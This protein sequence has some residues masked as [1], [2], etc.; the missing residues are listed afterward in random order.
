MADLGPLAGLVD[1]QFLHISGNP[2]ASLAPL[3]GLPLTELYASSLEGADLSGLGQIVS[4]QALDLG[5]NA[6][7]DIGELA[8]LVHL[9]SLSLYGNQLA[10]LSPLAGL[11]ALQGLNLSAN[12]LTDLSPLAGLTAMQRLDLDENAIVDLAPLTEMVALTRLTAEENAIADLAALAGMTALTELDLSHNQ[13][14]DL[15]P[16]AGLHALID[17]DLAV[18]HVVDVAP[19]ALPALF[20]LDLRDN[21][22]VD[23]AP[24]LGA[25]VLERLDVSG[26]PFAPSMT[27]LAAHPA[28]QSVVAEAAGLTAAPEF[29]TAKLVYLSL[30]GNA[31]TDLAPLAA[32]QS[33]EQIDLTDNA[34][35][36]L[37]AI[38][39]DPWL[40][41]CDYIQV[42]DNPLDEFTLSTTVPQLC[43]FPVDLQ[44][45]EGTPAGNASFTTER[46]PRRRR[47]GPHV[48]QDMLIRTCLERHT[49]ERR[50]LARLDG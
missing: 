32:Y 44:G 12:Q 14:V 16:L 3:A 43:A 17:L 9:T 4:L 37:A 20:D 41:K 48:S 28:L 38:L 33:L 26:N 13:I 25:P 8:P 2:I 1:L 18:N 23:L 11:V 5:N 19:L 29:A 42:G 35:T 30:A 15:A 49:I 6:L 47:P 50:A 34:V 36:A 27:S 46:A 31:I 45:I 39:D 22:V 21:Q 7:T 40:S 10:D 24:L